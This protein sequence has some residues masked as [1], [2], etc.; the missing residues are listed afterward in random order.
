[1]Y[2]I[3]QVEEFVNMIENVLCNYHKMCERL[4]NNAEMPLYDEYTKFTKL[5][6]VL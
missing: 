2:E 6:P 1:M 5:S 4:V 3:D